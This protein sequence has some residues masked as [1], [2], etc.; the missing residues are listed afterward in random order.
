MTDI[1]DVVRRHI[2]LYPVDPAMRWCEMLD[3]IDGQPCTRLFGFKNTKTHGLEVKEAAREFLDKNYTSGS[4]LWS[5]YCGYLMNFGR[6]MAAHYY[7]ED[8]NFYETTDLWYPN[9]SKEKLYNL[10]QVKELFSQFIPYFYIDTIED[11]YSVMEYARQYKNN[12]E[13]EML[14]KAGCPHFYKYK[15]FYRLSKHK[16]REFIQWIQN[17]AEYCKKYHPTYQFVSW[18]VKAHET[19]EETKLR[20]TIMCHAKLF[21]SEDIIFTYDQMAEIC[22][23]LEKQ[24]CDIVTYRD[25]L[26][27]SREI[28]RDIT[29]RGV[30]FPRNVIAQHEALLARKNKKQNRKINKVMGELKAKLNE[31]QIKYKG[32]QIIIP[33]SQ[34]ELVRLG[35]KL[36]N[37][38]GTMGFGEKIR[39]GKILI[40]EIRRNG[41]PLECCELNIEK[42]V[43][44]VQL[45]GDHNQPSEHHENAE[46]LV[47][48]F[49]NLY[50][51][52]MGVCAN[53]A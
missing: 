11:I 33:E 22:K 9:V 3:I 29:D 2:A 20:C 28:H 52:F 30:L 36:H 40:L 10:S 51:P 4:L 12:H 37:C 42:S 31:L 25:Y 44:I 19:A 46:K 41:E 16:K 8:N 45:R 5:H 38:V 43:N 32:L 1:P 49:I 39:K 26:V 15:A 7:D 53:A 24:D 34:E 14:A 18:S 35:N 48:K 27:M 47:C 21:K 23:Y 6:G 17:N 13:F 50:K